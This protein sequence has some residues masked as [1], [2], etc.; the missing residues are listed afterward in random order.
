M[1][2]IAYSAFIFLFFST[3]VIA[4]DVASQESIK[5]AGIQLITAMVIKNQIDA[6][7]GC[8]KK[9][10]ADINLSEWADVLIKKDK[11]TP[12]EKSAIIKA[13]KDAVITMSKTKAP[14]SDKTLAQ[15]TYSTAKD[16]AIKQNSSFVNNGIYC[17]VLYDFAIVSF[18]KSK[19]E[20]QKIVEN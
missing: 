8:S 12:A 3:N 17:D 13:Y 5:Q 4:A 20:I 10:Y 9:T 19:E 15:L 18:K 2:K 16:A 7:V 1:L 11:G 14:N 6:D